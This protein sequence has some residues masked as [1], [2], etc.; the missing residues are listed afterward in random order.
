MAKKVIYRIESS[1]PG[2]AGLSAAEPIEPESI[3]EGTPTPSDYNYFTNDTEQLHVGVWECTPG[4]LR[5]DS[6]PV[7]EYC[8]IIS[9]SVV[10][11]D[12]NRHAETF[13]A[14]ECFVIP[15][16]FKG[17]WH[18]PETVRKYYVIF[19]PQAA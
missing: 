3:I 7:D 11:T 19:E 17:T 18:M 12:E 9:G 15:K 14:G 2:G 6:H 4:T 13:K 10:I 1:A 16:G 8:F 5:L